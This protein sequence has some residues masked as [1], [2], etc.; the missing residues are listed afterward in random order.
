M[1]MKK[2]LA[3]FIFFVSASQ[4]ALASGWKQAGNNIYINTN[5]IIP[6]YNERHETTENEY[7]FWTRHFNDG[8]AYF[9]NYEAELKSKISIIHTRHIINC[10]D[11]KITTKTVLIYDDNQRL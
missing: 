3:F 10:Y 8:S 2:V 11:K 9:K 7:S 6:Y 4:F 1:D 5:S